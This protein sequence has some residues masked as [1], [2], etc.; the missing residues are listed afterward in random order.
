MKT[1]IVYELDG[2]LPVAVGQQVNSEAAR[3]GK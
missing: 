2:L 3:A 1:Y